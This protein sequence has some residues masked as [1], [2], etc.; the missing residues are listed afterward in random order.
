MQ[1]LLEEG[2]SSRRGIMNAH[3]E[4]AYAG[5]VAR[6]LEQSEAA[7]DSVILLPLYSEMSDDEFRR[8]IEA[9]KRAAGRGMAA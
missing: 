7:R 3:Q 8:V 5:F 4:A 1:R 2:I 9:L 6:G